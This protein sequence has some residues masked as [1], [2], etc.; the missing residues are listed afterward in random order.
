MK[1]VINAAEP[2]AA[3]VRV[4]LRRRDLAMP[5]HELDGA[6]IRSPFQKMGGK[7]MPQDMRA[8]VRGETGL[9]GILPEQLP[10]SLASKTFAAAR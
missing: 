5:Q 8:D 9:T 7:R 1:L 3:H 2:L 10:E 6:Q 4:D